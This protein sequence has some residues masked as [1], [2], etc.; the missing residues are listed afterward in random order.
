MCEFHS[1]QAVFLRARHRV[2]EMVRPQ[3]TLTA[4]A[5]AEPA[6]A[7]RPHRD[8][9]RVGD[10]R[11]CSAGMHPSEAKRAQPRLDSSCGQQNHTVTPRL[12]SSISVGRTATCPAGASPAIDSIPPSGTEGNPVAQLG[13]VLEVR[14]GIGNVE[15]A[16]KLPALRA[17]CVLEESPK[18]TVCYDRIR[19]STTQRTATR[20][21][22][23]WASTHSP[24]Q[25][26][27]KPSPGCSP[28]ALDN[29]VRAHL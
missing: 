27:P 10:G 17:A 12:Q 22:C 4:I 8:R 5:C 1:L 16:T 3:Q 29:S 14:S 9:E 2:F 24:L 6:T 7:N 25:P 20:A 11:G 28:L 21:A 15:G 18:W 19:T 13:K 23:K 26:K